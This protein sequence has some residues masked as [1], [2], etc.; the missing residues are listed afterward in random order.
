[1][2]PRGGGR[3]YQ[4]LYCQ[5]A[6]RSGG[7]GTRKGERRGLRGEEKEK[8]ERRG[9]DDAVGF[10]DESS[11]GKREKAAA[12]ARWN[13]EEVSRAKENGGG[14]VGRGEGDP[15]ARTHTHTLRDASKRET[16]RER[17]EDRG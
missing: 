4:L 7:P 8:R 2:P 10:S 1:M 3:R 14:E 9:T 15:N 5:V 6:K 11:R 13:P 17:R 12:S 16:D